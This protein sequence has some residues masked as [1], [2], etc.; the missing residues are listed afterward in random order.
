[1]E[2]LRKEI[3]ESRDELNTIRP[4]HQSKVAEEEEIAKGYIL[5]EIL[6]VFESLFSRGGFLSEIK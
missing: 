6:F 3:Q 2:S 5:T 4:L 1:M